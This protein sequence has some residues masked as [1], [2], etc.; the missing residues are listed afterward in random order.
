MGVSQS[1]LSLAERH[2]EALKRY[3]ELGAPDVYFNATAMCQAVGQRWNHYRENQSIQEFLAELG[4]STGIPADLLT[5]PSVWSRTS[6]A[7][8]GS[9]PTSPSTW[10]CGAAPSS[11]SGC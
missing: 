8:P 11:R 9:I 6:S 7:A 1:S 5:R 2:V 10:R 4:R 3:P